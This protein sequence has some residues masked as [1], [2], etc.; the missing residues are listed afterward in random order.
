M[1]AVISTVISERGSRRK[2]RQL[3]WAVA[4]GVIA[5]V[6]SLAVLLAS[7]WLGGDLRL[8]SGAPKA[9]L[10][11]IRPAAIRAE[12]I[13]PPAAPVLHRVRRADAPAQRSVEP[14]PVEEAFDILTAD[15]LAAIS[16]AHRSRPIP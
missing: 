6:V 7:A 16:Q 11:E 10:T 14:A 9:G 1:V 3:T 15:E 12:P 4:R 8:R 5:F 13:A 2:R